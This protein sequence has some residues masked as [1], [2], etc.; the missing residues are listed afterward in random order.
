MNKSIWFFG[1]LAGVLSALLEYL[2][3]ANIGGSANVM[4]VTKIAALVIC[5]TAGVVLIRKLSGGVIS[6]A[7]TVFSGMLISLIRAMVM[8]L[9]FGYLYYPSG[10][11][12]QPWIDQGWEQAEKK[13]A[14]DEKI[15]PA[16]KEMELLEIKEQIANLY[17]P[18]GYTIITIG[19]SLVTGLIFSVLLAAFIG[20]NMMYKDN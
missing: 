9:V 8:V 18:K 3:F 19:G 6:L 12:Y 15:K 2:F 13:V 1:V 10:D 17:K 14:Q 20:T 11:F 5:L 16:D 7:R 4:F